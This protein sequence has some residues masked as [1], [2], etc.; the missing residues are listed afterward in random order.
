MKQ[1]SRHVQQKKTLQGEAKK[2]YQRKTM[3]QNKNNDGTHATFAKFSW[4]FRKFFEVFVGSEMCLD[5][6]GPSRMRSDTFRCARKSRKRSEV[7]GKFPIF[8]KLFRNIS[9]HFAHV[10]QCSGWAIFSETPLPWPIF[11]VANFTD[12]ALPRPVDKRRF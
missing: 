12:T 4:S 2:A 5:L 3:Q 11:F 10:L 9:E 1:D 6:F 7:F 8:S